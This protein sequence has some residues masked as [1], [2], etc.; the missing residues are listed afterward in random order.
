MSSGDACAGVVHQRTA[1]KTRSAGL[2]IA[3]P[4]NMTA[5]SDG[6]RSQSARDNAVACGLLAPRGTMRSITRPAP[7]LL[8][9][10]ACSGGSHV[11]QNPPGDDAGVDATPDASPAQDAAPEATPDVNDAGPSEGQDLSAEPMSVYESDDQIAVA[12]AGTIGVAWTAF[13]SKPPY[14]YF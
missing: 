3:H 1:M 4:S 9:L 5:V 12:P 2:R 8:V 11:D 14:I 7:L 6:T 13:V 10:A